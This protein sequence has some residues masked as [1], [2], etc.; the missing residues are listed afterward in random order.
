MVVMR[1][2]FVWEPDGGPTPA[3][4]HFFLATSTILRTSVAKAIAAVK[5]AT[6]R[7]AVLLSMSITS[8]R[9]HIAGLDL[10][11]RRGFG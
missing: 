7:N 2:L 3:R 1:L 6:I 10:R 9:Q 11:R 5:M 8:L 4:R